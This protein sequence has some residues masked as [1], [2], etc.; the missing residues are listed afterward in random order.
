MDRWS[1]YTGKLYRENAR[2]RQEQVVTSTGDRYIQVV[3]KAGL[4]V[5]RISIIITFEPPSPPPPPTPQG[6]L[7]DFLWGIVRSTVS[8]IYLK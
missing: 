6:I 2:G 7:W 5:Y 8:S 3:V 4:T 1:Q